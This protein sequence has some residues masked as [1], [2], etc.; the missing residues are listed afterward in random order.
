MKP[1]DAPLWIKPVISHENII[2]LEGK[3]EEI[4]FTSDIGIYYVFYCFLAKIFIMAKLLRH[5]NWLFFKQQRRHSK[6]WSKQEI[7]LSI[8]IFLQGVPKLLSLKVMSNG[9]VELKSA[10]LYIA[11]FFTKKSMK[12]LVTLS[13]IFHGESK[14]IGF[15]WFQGPK[16]LPLNY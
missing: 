3:N 16:I 14:N 6:Y 2:Y 12:W 9:A 5:Y 15:R 8:I 4:Y 11:L 13:P 7:I 1:E 10:P